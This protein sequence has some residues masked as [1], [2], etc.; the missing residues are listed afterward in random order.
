MI[1]HGNLSETIGDRQAN[2]MDELERA[3]RARL[4]AAGRSPKTITSRL[5]MLRRL[6]RELPHGLAEVSTAD[7]EEWLLPYDGWTLNTYQLAIR[8]IGRFLVS[9]GWNFDP[10]ANLIR[11]R[12]PK[13]EPRPASDD[14]ITAALAQTREPTRTAVILATF[15]GLR[16][17]EVARLDRLD[18][19]R[20][21]LW[22]T[23]KGGRRMTLPTHE[24]VWEHLR[25]LPAGPVVRTVGGQQF[26]ASYLSHIVSVEL[27]RI[28][29]HDLT[30][31]RFRSAF[32]TRL[33]Q[34]GVH[35]TVIQELMGHESLDTTQRYIKVSDEQRRQ[36]MTTLLAPPT[37][38]LQAAA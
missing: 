34:A 21:D 14:E 2:G 25:P 22:V 30:L 18:V 17:S 11:P 7:L 5:E 8:D 35:A 29:L 19:D 27:S 31:H 4:R 38:R 24:L 1:A 36:A 6:N 33:A 15:D 12:P 16:V 20:R 13:A 26:G 23:R 3:Y 37:A 32:A 28:G 10:A 9:Q